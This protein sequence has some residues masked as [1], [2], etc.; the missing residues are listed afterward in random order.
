MSAEQDF[1]MAWK[2]FTQKPN[3]ALQRFKSAVAKSTGVDVMLLQ[4]M[5]ILKWHFK[6]SDPDML[7]SEIESELEG[8]DDEDLVEIFS[9]FVKCHKG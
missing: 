6:L 3:D 9:N 7:W 2:R 5:D 4:S 1:S 8:F